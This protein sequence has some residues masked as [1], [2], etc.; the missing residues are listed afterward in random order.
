MSGQVGKVEMLAIAV[1][2]GQSVRAWAEA[3]D[4]P[5]RTAY[6]WCNTPEFK[7]RVRTLRDELVNRTLGVMT[8]ASVKAAR[9]MESLLDSP[10]E[11]V[12]L[13]AARDLLSIFLTVRSDVDLAERVAALE[14]L[15]EQPLPRP[16]E[17]A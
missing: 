8:E 2:V 5:V 1:A 4:V 17:S 7:A 15:N 6:R 14:A 13:N 3:N 16:P 10:V 9:V 11:R 12:R